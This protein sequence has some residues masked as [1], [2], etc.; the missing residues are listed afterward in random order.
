ME[1]KKARGET[2]VAMV[3]SS[4][5]IDISELCLILGEFELLFWRRKKFSIYFP[6]YTNEVSYS[7]KLAKKKFNQ[8]IKRSLHRWLKTFV[9]PL[10]SQVPEHFNSKSRQFGPQNAWWW[11]QISWV[12]PFRIKNNRYFMFT[13]GQI[14]LCSLESSIFYSALLKLPNWGNA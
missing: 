11:K 9:Y 13:S 7:G 3:N 1:K 4:A 12:K 6:S 5:K 2:P 8:Q 10:I 14:S